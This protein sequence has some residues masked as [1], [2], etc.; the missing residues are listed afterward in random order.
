DRWA[1]DVAHELKTPLTSIRLVAETLQARLDPP[2]RAWVDRLIN[3]V[4]RL[5]NLVQD[6]LD[7]SQLQTNAPARL[8]LKP[9]NLAELVQSAWLS[10]ELL[11]RKKHI[12][13][14]YVGANPAIIY[15]DEPRL[16]RVLINLLDNGIKYSPP[17]QSIQVNVKFCDAQAVCCS[18]SS[19]SH[20]ETDKRQDK[21]HTGLATY[22]EQPLQDQHVCLDVIDAGPGFQEQDLPYVFDRFYQ[23]DLSRTRS[24]KHGSSS[25]LASDSTPEYLLGSSGLGLAIVR[26]IVEA[27]HGTVRASNH[28][29]TG[30]AWLQVLLPCHPPAA[31]ELPNPAK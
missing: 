1:S 23:A 7:L 15:A 4:I 19:S 26:Q 22:D 17:R 31:S 6:L 20:L 29:E 24:S 27:H 21:E 12:T 28:P 3:E 10:L 30:G 25:A 14:N 2:L 8:T 16:Y 18:P 9:V 13:L 5:S 11:A